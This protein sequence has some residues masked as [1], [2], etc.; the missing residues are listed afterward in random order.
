LAKTS[1][2]TADPYPTLF[3]PFRLGHVEAQ[4]RIVSTSHGQNLAE[5]G[6]PSDRLIASHAAKAEGGCG[7]VMMFGSEAASAMPPM[8]SN[9]VNLRM[10]LAVPGLTAAAAVKAHGALAIG[11]VIA[12]GRRTNLY[13]DMVRRG[14]S[15]TVGEVSHQARTS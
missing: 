13:V 10:D 11:Q 6:A 2:R 9:H 7:T 12:L 1:P 4:N 15:D 8:P 3:S 5:G 14:P